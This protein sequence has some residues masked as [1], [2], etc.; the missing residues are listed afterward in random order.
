MEPEDLT[1]S[2]DHLGQLVHPEAR[3]KPDDEEA[4]VCQAN[5]E[6]L[7]LL[8]TR[9]QLEHQERPD[10]LEELGQLDQREPVDH[11]ETRVV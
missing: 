3:E 7:V 4:M 6:R 2:Q 9:D 8:E 1:D 5:V 11:E 10:Q